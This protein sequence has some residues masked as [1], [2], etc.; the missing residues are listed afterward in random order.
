[1]AKPADFVNRYR[2]AANQFLEAFEA[3]EQ[4]SIEHDII[5][6]VVT[7]ANITNGDLTGAEFEA[8]LASVKTI[9]TTFTGS[10]HAKNVYKLRQ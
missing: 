5:Q 1:M 2:G 9:W 8:G 7:D 4:M 6:L 10:A 3:L